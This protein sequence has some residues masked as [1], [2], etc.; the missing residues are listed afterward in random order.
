MIATAEAPKNLT[1]QQIKQK[2]LKKDIF[3]AAAD[4]A[5]SQSLLNEDDWGMDWDEQLQTYILNPK[6]TTEEKESCLQAAKK[7][8]R[9]QLR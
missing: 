6:L 2:E 8:L 3:K 7:S 5:R 4:H 1:A 9:G